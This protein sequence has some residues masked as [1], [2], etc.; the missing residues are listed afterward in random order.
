MSELQLLRAVWEVR[1][2]AEAVFFDNRGKIASRW[3][4][5]DGFD[6]WRLAQNELRLHSSDNSQAF[7]ANHHRA[8]YVAEGQALKEFCDKAAKVSAWTLASLKIKHITRVGFRIHL[9]LERNSFEETKLSMLKTVFAIRDDEWE[10]FGGEPL[11]ISVPFTLQFGDRKA[12]FKMGPVKR[13][14][15]ID[16]I[17]ESETIKERLPEAGILFDFDMYKENPNFQ[18]RNLRP[19]FYEFIE[20]AGKQMQSISMGILEH[21]GEFSE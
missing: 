5:Q 10:I 13:D 6:N 16:T 7:V 19:D 18:S 3:H 17:I 2:P 15:L 9:L 1:F 11:D 21:Y 8:F 4:K 12:N 20:S 14:E